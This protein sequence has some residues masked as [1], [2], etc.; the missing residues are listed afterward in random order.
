[1]IA[2]NTKLKIRCIVGLTLDTD[3][4]LYWGLITYISTRFFNI[5]HDLHGSNVYS[6]LDSCSEIKLS[7]ID[8]LKKLFY[9]NFASYY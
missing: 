1:M 6:L 5:I 2:H 7:K 9:A 3:C 8:Y 4:V